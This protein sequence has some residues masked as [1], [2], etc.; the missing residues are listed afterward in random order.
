MPLC[1]LPRSTFNT[2]F[3]RTSADA[4]YERPNVIGL[5]TNVVDTRRERFVIHDYRRRLRP[6]GNIRSTYGRQTRILEIFGI[7]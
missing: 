4:V 6:I 2:Y 7:S 3:I 5:I 1:N